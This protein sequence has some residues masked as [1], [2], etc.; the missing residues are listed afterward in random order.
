MQ[1]RTLLIVLSSLLLLKSQ[2]QNGIQIKSCRINYVYSTPI[3]KGTKT[4]IFTDSGKI[5]KE[6]VVE[7]VDTTKDIGIPKQLIGNRSVN[8]LLVIKTKDSVFSIDLDSLT[9]RK[10]RNIKTAWDISPLIN[11]NMIKVTEDTFL[12]KKCDIMDFYGFKIWYW[13]GIPVKKVP[14]GP[15]NDQGFEYATLIDENYVI[16]EDEFNIPTGIKMQ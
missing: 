9:G 1:K 14:P 15:Q 2:S 10:R 3:S 6:I 8:N 7:Y 16:K 12:N 5:Y 13:K 11:G 4:I